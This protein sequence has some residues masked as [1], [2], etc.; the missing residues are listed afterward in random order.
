MR[1]AFWSA[2]P[3]Q[4]MASATSPVGASVTCSQL[5]NLSLSRANARS[6][7]T[8]EVCCDSTVA[9]TS[10][11][12]GSRGLG[13]NAPCWA[14][15]R[16][17]TAAGGRPVARSAAGPAVRDSGLIGLRRGGCN[18]PA[19]LPRRAIPA[20]LPGAG[21]TWQPGRSSRPRR[22]VPRSHPGA[23]PMN[24]TDFDALSFDCY[25]TLIDWEAGLSAVLVPWARAH[26]LSLT[27]ERLLAEYSGAEAT[28]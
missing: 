17:C 4:R 9:T 21:R 6:E 13:T 11:R 23:R 14:R 7:L 24:L 15:S 26:G 28:V 10:S 8:S 20:G 16:R 5:G 3:P 18:C 12:T 19:R 22:T 25:G 2:M 1:R 27:E